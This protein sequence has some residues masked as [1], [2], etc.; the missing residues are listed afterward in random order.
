MKSRWIVLP[1]WIGLASACAAQASD[2]IDFRS[3][4][5]LANKRI[6]PMGQSVLDSG[7]YW[8]HGETSHFVFHGT[9]ARPLA[10]LAPEAEFYFRKIQAVVGA[11]AAG[12]RVHVYVVSDSKTWAALQ[13]QAGARADGL[14]MQAE[15]EIFILENDGLAGADRLPH[16]I[17]HYQI[18]TMFGYR[19]P[20][21][22]DE[23]VAAYAGWKAAEAWHKSK[24]R[25]LVRTVPGIPAGRWIA[26]DR[27]T[28]LDQYPAGDEGAA[29]QRESEELVT[30]IARKIGDDQLSSVLGAV[31]ADSR[32]WRTFLRE[33]YSYTDADFQWLENEVRTRCE[34]GT[35]EEM[36]SN[37]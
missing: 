26:L 8:M 22:L 34:R 27:L 23:G 9:S 36:Q 2:C 24:G 18:W 4:D 31:S 16:E 32:G 15:D 20:V 12:M 11:T 5:A 6:S 17:A 14:A 25:K 13:K 10:A 37:P 29:F 19:V 35:N 30:G 21:W 7:G 28:A 3:W 1:L 33:R